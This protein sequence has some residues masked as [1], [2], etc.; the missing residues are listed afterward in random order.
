M[1]EDQQLVEHIG[2]LD[3]Q[4]SSLQDLQLARVVT[5]NATAIVFKGY[6]SDQ[7]DSDED[8]DDGRLITER[9][10]HDNGNKR[11]FRTYRRVGAD[12]YGRGGWE[13]LV[14]EKHYDV[15]GVCRVDVHFALGQPYL[16]R[17]HFFENQRLKSEQ[18]FWVEEE[19]TMKCKKIGWWRQYYDNGNVRSEIQYNDKGI[20]IGFAK[21]YGP[22]GTIE[23]VKDYT[24]EYE[25]RARDFNERKGKLSF[26]E[27]DAAI[28]LGFD[29]IP[30][31]LAEVN[32]RYRMLCAPL[33]PDK[34]PDP[35][36]TEI[37]IRL[38]RARDVLKDFFEGKND[39][40]H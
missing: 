4:T 1:A 17:K 36:A 33:H 26:S 9:E 40:K 15:D 6:T 38:S 10:Y 22:D 20:R 24:K 39:D 23:W 21:R 16:Y 2:R 18:V 3:L 19:R 12:S 8:E 11:H 13:R 28:M 31:T 29:D 35:E 30:A 14:E 34:Q 5:R 25:D 32:S 37:F 27:K 7:D